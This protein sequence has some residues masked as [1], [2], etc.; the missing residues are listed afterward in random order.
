MV[1]RR[2][3]LLI[4]G[5]DLEDLNPGGVSRATRLT[6]AI[7]EIFK[8]N[9]TVPI[10]EIVSREEIIGAKVRQRA[11]ISDGKTKIEP[12]I[13]DF[14]ENFG[15]WFLSQFTAHQTL[16]DLPLRHPRIFNN[17]Q[18]DLWRSMI[19]DLAAQAQGLVAGD[20]RAH[21]RV[22]RDL[23][24]VDVHAARAAADRR[25]EPA[26]GVAE[27]DAVGPRGVAPAAERRDEVVGRVV[28]EVVALAGAGAP[29]GG[30]A[31]AG[32]ERVLVE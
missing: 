32:V 20:E 24:A 3:E 7:T 2:K 28:L 8:R 21:R 30:G 25:G 22:G 18:A 17:E 6:A 1:S 10:S 11:P 14:V 15:E 5:M 26:P 9:F 23:R 31:A 19:D 27:I 16:R 4:E 12:Y 29:L 13:D